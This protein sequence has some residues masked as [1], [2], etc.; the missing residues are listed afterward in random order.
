MGEV[1]LTGEVRSVPHVDRRISDAT[2]LGFKN[3]IVSSNQKINSSYPSVNIIKVKNIKMMIEK[4]NL[5][6]GSKKRVI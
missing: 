2:R 5:A 1:G 4:L 6:E 3:I